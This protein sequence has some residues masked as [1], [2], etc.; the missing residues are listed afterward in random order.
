MKFRS[1]DLA[2]LDG[3]SGCTVKGQKSRPRSLLRPRFL[4]CS[5]P[6]SPSGKATSICLFNRVKNSYRNIFPS[7]LLSNRDGQLIDMVD[8][9]TSKVWKGHVSLHPR[10]RDKASYLGE[11]RG[12]SC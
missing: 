9:P 11:M 7:F 4:L 1:L 5:W 2:R 3:E 6:D 8:P 12:N 10:K